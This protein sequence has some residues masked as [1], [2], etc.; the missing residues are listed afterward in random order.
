MPKLMHRWLGQTMAT[1]ITFVVIA[2]GL[3]LI[4]AYTAAS[5]TNGDA[6][7]GRQVFKKCAVCHSLEPGKTLVGPSLAGVV[8]R[9]AGSEPDYDYSPAMKQSGLVWRPRNSR[10]LS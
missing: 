1:A 8:G 2:A 7:A 4:V 3:S 6:T 10:F 5:M 9:K